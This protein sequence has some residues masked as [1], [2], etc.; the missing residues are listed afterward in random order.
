MDGRARETVTPA[1]RS[2]PEEEANARREYGAEDE[3]DLAGDRTFT[4]DCGFTNVG[5]S[6]V[7]AAGRPLNPM[8]FIFSHL[9]QLV[10]EAG[11]SSD[12][13]LRRRF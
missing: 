4:L 9:L 1:R 6:N 2:S 11:M 12:I 8:Q 5:V 7:M 10:P 3:I 13:F